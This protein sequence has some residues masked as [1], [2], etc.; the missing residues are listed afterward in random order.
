VKLLVTTIADDNVSEITAI[1]RPTVLHF[2]EEWGAD[3]LQLDHEVKIGPTHEPGFVSEALYHYRILRL[4]RLLETYDRIL[5]LDADVLIMPDCP[6]PFDVVPEDKIGTVFDDYGSRTRQ[7]QSVMTKVQDY[8]GEL[9]WRSGFIN[10]GVFV[11]S[12]Q[13]RNIFRDVRGEHWTEWGCAHTHL[14]YRIRQLDMPVHELPF[15]FNHMGMFSEPWNGSPNPFDSYII[16]YAGVAT[17]SLS[18]MRD[19]FAKVTEIWK[20]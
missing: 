6:N 10:T 17:R 16:H 2:V 7:R 1:T 19:D 8:W 14:G 4:G 3:F 18:R 12:Q 11:V 13:H 9:G 5:H 20:S 15:Q